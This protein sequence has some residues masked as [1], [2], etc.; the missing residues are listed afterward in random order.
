M[1]STMYIDEHC[2]VETVNLVSAETCD[3]H[4]SCDGMY[5]IGCLLVIQ[6]KSKRSVYAYPT[7]QGRDAAF[8]ALGAMVKATEALM[9]RGD[10]DD[11]EG[12]AR[13]MP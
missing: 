11:D 13:N 5:F 4:G 7:R 1:P 9:Q 12:D 8:I 3:G 2:I 10:G 6:G